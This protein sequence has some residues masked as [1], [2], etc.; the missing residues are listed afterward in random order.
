VYLTNSR[1]RT[2]MKNLIIVFLMLSSFTYAN[3]DQEGNDFAM[4][5]L[6][7]GK[8]TGNCGIFK[9]QLDF[10]DNTKLKGGGEFLARFWTME[11][12]RLGMPLEEFV[13]KCHKV[14]AKY[15]VYFTMFGENAETK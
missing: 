10:Q 9:L 7:T 15:D 2:N 14:V 4:D 12:A 5:L 3:E 13:N 8:L 6:A 1:Y 11:A